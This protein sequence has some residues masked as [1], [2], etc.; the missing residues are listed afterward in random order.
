MASIFSFKALLPALGKEVLVSANTHVDDLK[1]QIEIVRDNPLT[2]LNVIKPYLK[3][4]EEKNPIKHFPYGLSA[5][6][7]L[8]AQK[9]MALDNSPSLYIYIQTDKINGSHEYIGLI[10]TVP[11]EDYYAG[12]IKIHEKTLTEKEEQLIMHIEAT[13]VIGEPVLMTHKPASNVSDVLKSV[14]NKGE[15][16]IHFHDEVDRIHRI[17]KIC[18]L[19]LIKLTQTN[20]VNCGT[21]EANKKPLNHSVSCTVIVKDD[22]WKSVTEYLYKNQEYFTAVS[23]LPY[24]GD[25]IY[26]QAPM[27]AVINAEDEEKFNKLQAEWSQVDFTKLIE[28]EDETSHTQEAACAGGKCEPVSL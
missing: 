5:L 15:E 10:C 21:T 25:K 19:E 17:L 12:R 14:C 11:V 2:Y 28:D 16:I 26:Q 7:E 13:G 27:E 6:N 4:N 9:A 3:F 23:L 22:E 1:R 20:W 24:S 8:I 18:D